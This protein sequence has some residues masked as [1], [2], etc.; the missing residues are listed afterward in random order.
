MLDILSVQG[1]VEYPWE[2]RIPKVFWRGRDSNRER[3]NLVA[4]SRKHDDLINAS[5]TNFFFFR[6]EEHIYGP[7]TE[8]VSFFK[9]FDVIFYI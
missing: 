1:N 9:F 3:L 8:H 2:D 4:L 7:K 5:L 6:E